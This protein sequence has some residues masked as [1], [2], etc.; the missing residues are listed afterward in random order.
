MRTVDERCDYTPALR[1]TR[2]RRE[3][4][5][6][7]IERGGVCEAQCEA[8]EPKG[9]ALK[10][11]LR[12]PSAPKIYGK[13]RNYELLFIRQPLSAMPPITSFSSFYGRN[14]WNQ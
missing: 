1:N 11:R 14:L 4:G 3:Y 12:A 2:I 8:T 13:Q 10:S 9:E 5:L 6:R 7:R